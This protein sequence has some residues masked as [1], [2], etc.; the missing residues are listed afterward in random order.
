M[1]ESVKRRARNVPVKRSGPSH[2]AAF[3]LIELLV[4]IA[5]IA[6][7]AGMLLPALSR[8][9]EKAKCASCM[10]NLRQIGIALIAYADDYSGALI[11]GAVP[12]GSPLTSWYNVLDGYMG[13][14]DTDFSSAKR[15]AWQLCPSKTV[16][17]LDFDTVG[18]GWN[19]IFFGQDPSSPGTGWG[20]KLADVTKPTRT[21]IIGDSKDPW[22]D[23]GP[24]Y[25]YQH[26]YLYPYTG[27]DPWRASR[28][29]GKG[30]YLMVDG[31]V[32]PLIPLMDLTLF[33]KIQP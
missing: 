9:R 19:H 18:Y 21:I 2:V 22:A 29:S 33:W 27:Q 30:N 17:P 23:P 15:P 5:I 11:P 28:H 4:V 16:T 32:E 6:I 20:S 25:S 1:L 10:S 8:A 12:Y 26:R 14:Q 31:H 24:V 7:L 13:K 3:T